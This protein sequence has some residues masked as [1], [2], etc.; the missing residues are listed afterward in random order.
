[1]IRR[2]IAYILFGLSSLC[3]SL[4]KHIITKEKTVVVDALT[5]PGYFIIDCYLVKNTKLMKGFQLETWLLPE[6][7]IKDMNKEK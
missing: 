6:Q 3:K 5:L 4:G 2:Y 1:M 7:Y